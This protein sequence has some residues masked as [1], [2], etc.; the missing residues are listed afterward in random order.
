MD[1]ELVRYGWITLDVLEM[2]NP[3]H[4]AVTKDGE[5]RTVGMVKMLVWYADS[6]VKLRYEYVVLP[7]LAS[8]KMDLSELE[9]AF[10]YRQ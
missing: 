8:I 6:K 9:I 3:Y 1:K 10:A 4:S 7:S 5:L 2:R